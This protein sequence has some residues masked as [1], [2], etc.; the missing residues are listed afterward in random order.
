M[1][2]C[3]CNLVHF[4]VIHHNTSYFKKASLDSFKTILSQSNGT[5]VQELALIAQ[6]QRKSGETI[7][8]IHTYSRIRRLDPCWIQ[9]MDYYASLLDSQGNSSAI[10]K[11]SND[12]LSLANNS[13]E[14]WTV[15]SILTNMKG[16]AKQALDHLDKAL[17]LNSR[18]SLAHHQKGKILLQLEKPSEA[19]VCFRNAYRISRD[20]ANYE[21]T[22]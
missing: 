8:A 15:F 17:L 14:S 22:V 20:I 3:I 1:G 2:F 21:G 7:S 6:V 4:L 12:L 9:D 5:N 11:L 16:N 18:H 10:E 19:S 13:P